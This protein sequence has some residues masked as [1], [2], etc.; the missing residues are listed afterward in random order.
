MNEKFQQMLD[1]D[2]KIAEA[3]ARVEMEKSLPERGMLS[4]GIFDYITEGKNDLYK[5]YYDA[6]R[7]REMQD[8]QMANQRQMQEAQ[9]ANAREM[10]DKQLANSLRL[11]QESRAA[12]DAK[13]RSDQ[14]VALQNASTR[15]SYAAAML[16]KAKEEGDW[17]AIQNARK[18][19]DLANNSYNDLATSLGIQTTPMEET[20]E[21]E[22]D[23]KKTVAYNLAAYSEVD[24]NST[25]DEID[26]A[27]NNLAQFKTADAAKRIAQLDV[28]RK[29]AVNMLNNK[30]L[31]QKAVGE[32][33]TE[34]GYVPNLLLNKKWR[35]EKRGK[36][37]VLLD[38]NN[39]VVPL[40]KKSG[41]KSSNPSEDNDWN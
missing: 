12:Q 7:A 10:Q 18:E 32:F 23:P 22:Y 38:E 5:G 4:P 40:P 17:I 1:L 34:T 33:D 29:K 28:A 16:N 35:S 39:N 30:A 21:E 24:E 13:I 19:F 3:R 20:A 31:I 36:S 14:Q 2:Q 6:V 27:R 26:E 9:M 41:K 8:A 25:L 15:K 11:A 37:Y